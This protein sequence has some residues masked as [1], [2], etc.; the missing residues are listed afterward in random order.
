[1]AR[2][3]LRVPIRT[4]AEL[5][6]SAITRSGLNIKAAREVL[7]SILLSGV[8]AL[9]ESSDGRKSNETSRDHMHLTKLGIY[10]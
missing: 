1:M 5:E 4:G 2:F 8:G 10:N 3:D 9:L 7:G 6:I